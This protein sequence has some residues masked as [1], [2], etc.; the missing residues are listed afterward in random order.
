MAVLAAIFVFPLSRMCGATAELGGVRVAESGVSLQGKLGLTEAAMPYLAW[1]RTNETAWHESSAASLSNI[2]QDQSVASF[3]ATFAEVRAHLRLEQLSP[4]QWRLSGELK[5]N[6]KEPVE[7]ARFH[8]LDGILAQGLS[9][10]NLQ[11][12]DFPRIA[13]LGDSLPAPRAALEKMWKDARVQ[14]PGLAEPIHDGL[15]W[16]VSTD[17][18]VFSTAWDQPGWTVG[19]TGPGTAFGEIGFR[20]KPAPGRFFIG[21]LLDNILLDAG[22]T[23]VLEHVLLHYGNW[24][25]GMNTWARECA[26]EFKVA[27]PK[28]PIV[29]YCSWYQ[30]GGRVEV[31]DLMRAAEE[32]REYPTPPGGKLVQVD[33]GWQIKPGVWSPNARFA[34]D[35]AGLPER[36]RKMGSTPGTYLV[37]TAIHETHPIVKEHPEWLQHLPSGELAVHFA[38]WGGKTYFLEIDRP[39]AKDFMRKIFEQTRKEG[40]EYIKIDFAYGFSTARSAWNRKKTSFESLR[41]LHA[42]FREAAGPKMLLNACVGEPARY[43]LGLADVTRLRGDIG[44]SWTIVQ[45]NLK[46]VLT[47]SAPTG[48]WWQSDPDVFYMRAENSRLKPEESHLLTGTLG[49]FG[50]VF[51]T[52]DWPTQWSPAAQDVVREFWTTDGPQPPTTQQVLWSPEGT[53]RAYRVSYD[54]EKLPQHRVGIYNWSDQAADVRIPLTDLG[55]DPQSNWSI[56]S[57][58]W[59]KG[60]QLQDGQIVFTNQP[61]HSLRI[62]NLQVP[63][64]PDAV[65]PQVVPPVADGPSV[66]LTDAPLI[67]FPGGHNP[68]RKADFPADCHS[69]L[70]WVGDTLYVFNSWERPWRGQGKDLFHLERGFATKMD[71]TVT[72]LWLWLESTWRDDDGTLYGWVHNEFPN[73]C[74]DTG[75]PVQIAPGYPVLARIGAVKSTDNGTNWQSLG[76]VMDGR[77]K[78]IKCDGEGPW[79]AGGVGDC[80]V[81]LDE[82]REYF[83]IYFASFAPDVAEQGLCVARMRFADRNDPVGKVMIWHQGKWE[84]P[85]VG[86]GHVTPFWPV[87]GDVHRKECFIFW[88]PSIHW[89]TYLNKYVMVVNRTKTSRWDTDGQYVSFSDT[90]GDPTAWSPPVKFSEAVTSRKQGWYVQ[91]VGTGKGETDKLASR[92]AR[93]FVDGESKWE[94]RF[95]KP[96]EK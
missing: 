39:E 61:P 29:G 49:M 8:Y 17:T 18:A 41:D 71:P 47:L 3:D 63:P 81:Y 86:G 30:K 82:N 67:T 50:G 22:E 9:L 43:A 92:T 34:A 14:L 90:L 25:E 77:P 20:T 83:Y 68:E 45:N 66:V 89:N 69:P 5:N 53:P 62:A 94:I 31:K 28:P 23:R 75:R 13:R 46:K 24:Q 1:R 59:S 16:S 74:P 54:R 33:D 15:D 91:V 42:L 56:T 38:N 35:W 57:S 85:A 7:L 10:L 11:G 65:R 52:S 93:L 72:N 76:F 32:L 36:I 73:V 79:Y 26:R 55:V 78:E 19:F 37:P 27:S 58:E 12:G 84:Q 64:R 2:Q 21:V 40:W 6:G 48:L 60:I 95:R 80:G 44:T 70:H 88:G 4:N 96:G 51:L 87:V